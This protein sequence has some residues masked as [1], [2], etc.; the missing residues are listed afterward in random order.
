M[1]SEQNLISS[2]QSPNTLQDSASTSSL[3]FSII[4]RKFINQ[5]IM[6][7]DDLAVHSHFTNVC[8]CCNV[9]L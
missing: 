1:I 3:M 2:F 9:L 4:A 5:S 7:S 8:F 6:L